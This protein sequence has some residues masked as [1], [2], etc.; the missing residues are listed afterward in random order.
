MAAK[1]AMTSSS[2]SNID[3]YLT[4]NVFDMMSL[5]NRVVVVTGGAKGIGLALAFAVAEAGGQV[6]ILD[7]AQEPHEH[8]E[9]LEQVCPKLRYYQSGSPAPYT[10]R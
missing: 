7:A 9:K 10:S 4:S 3:S 6:A 1:T 2:S 8:Y 5:S